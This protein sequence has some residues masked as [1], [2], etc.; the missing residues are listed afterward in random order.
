MTFGPKAPATPVLDLRTRRT[1]A[2][3]MPTRKRN[4]YVAALLLA[5]AGILATVVLEVASLWV[6]TELAFDVQDNHPDEIVSVADSTTGLRPGD[7]IVAI[8]GLG[9]AGGSRTDIVARFGAAARAAGRGP[10][11]MTVT[12][13]MGEAPRRVVVTPTLVESPGDDLVSVLFL[14]PALLAAGMGLLA[15]GARTRDPSVERFVGLCLVAALP[16]LLLAFPVTWE[17]Y[18]APPVPR[19]MAALAGIGL[20]VVLGLAGL[21][22]VQRWTPLFNGAE[23]MPDP[24]ESASVVF[25][26]VIVSLGLFT[27]W[28]LYRALRSVLGLTRAG[29]GASDPEVRLK[30]R[31]A[32]LGLRTG[33]FAFAGILTAAVLLIVGAFVFGFLEATGVVA[34]DGD[35]G[36]TITGA[37]AVAF[38]VTAS[39]C[40]FLALAAPFAGIG[41]SVMRQGLWN[42]DLIAS[43]TALVSLLGVGFV[44]VWAVADE[45][46]EALVPGQLALA[47]PI[48][49][50]AA[51]ASVR[52]PLSRFVRRALFPDAVDVPEAV[53][54]S[55]HRLAAR[56]EE[57]RAVGALA[58]VLHEELGADP[59]AVIRRDPDGSA[60]AEWTG[61]I[62]P[63]LT[64]A[65]L[66]EVMRALPPRGLTVRTDAGPFVALPMGAD[67][68]ALIG[69]LPDGRPPDGEGRRMLGVMLAMAGGRA[70]LPR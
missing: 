41:L 25:A 14:L 48:L 5:I 63:A 33:A 37:P 30:L 52:V 3:E 13:S 58:S 24:A 47:G 50:G 40:F 38:S 10:Y 1:E 7:R 69:P 11:E 20:V 19:V 43:R 18:P 6:P 4:A 9:V 42:V 46:I 68:A 57:A 31:W 39:A 27:L 65:Q 51:V 44:G 64:S 26:V 61:S 66:G 60:R 12:D 54:R 53:E 22:A 56:P 28:W 32:V 45:L 8:G 49:A 16:V 2:E 59:V 36:L 35:G 21:A 62:G 15:L 70:I 55:A 29:R 34:G 23:W 67:A 17:R